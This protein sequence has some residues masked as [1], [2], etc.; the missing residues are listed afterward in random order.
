MT[1]FTLFPRPVLG[2]ET[3]CDE[4]SAAWLEGTRV[5][6]NVVS[7]Q[8]ALHSRWGGVVPEAAARAHVEAIVPVLSEA[9]GGLRAGAVAVT[10]RPGLVGALSVGVSAAKAL[11]LAWDIPL[12]GV[13]HLEGHVLSPYLDTDDPLPFPHLCL[14][15]SGGHTELVR[16]AGLGRYRVIAETVDDAAGEALDKGARLLGLGYPGGRAVQEAAIGGDPERYD[17]PRG[18]IDDA[19]RFSFSGLKTAMLRLVEREGSSLCLADAAAS[20]QEAVVD[21]LV[22]KAV[23][24]VEET[25]VHA[26]SVVGGVAANARL[27][28]RLG[29]ECG[30]R[31]VRLAAPDPEYCTDNA[32]MVALAGSARLAKGERGSWAMDCCAHSPLPED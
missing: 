7:S 13:H 1:P 16:V 3:S 8:A 28:E 27:R 11:A 32:A 4:T 6:T 5:V 17:L 25:G 2:I 14:V 20:L 24:A 21:S 29:H 12:V 18:V 31:G 22:S 30:K 15:V 26:L 10:N 19:S 9:A 23:S